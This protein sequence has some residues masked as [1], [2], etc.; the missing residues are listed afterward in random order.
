[1]FGLK[2]KAV[3]PMVQYEPES[4]LVADKESVVEEVVI[5]EMPSDNIIHTAIGGFSQPIQPM[6]DE[7]L[8]LIAEKVHLEHR[9]E[10]KTWLGIE[11]NA[12]SIVERRI[13]EIQNRT[14]DII[15]IDRARKLG[16][17]VLDL[18]VLEET[19]FDTQ[20]GLN[21]PRLILFE[22][23]TPRYD[24]YF[25]YGDYRSGMDE[26]HVDNREFYIRSLRKSFLH[27]NKLEWYRNRGEGL[28]G[29]SYHLSAYF[30]SVIP[31]EAAKLINQGCKDFGKSNVYLLA[32]YT[33]KVKVEQRNNPESSNADP[34]IMAK[35]NESVH[36][37][38]G[39]FDPTPF[40]EYI[41]R[42]H[43]S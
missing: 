15:D 39:M 1:M 40:E 10:S 34:L 3:Q 25:E 4:V 29:I 14:R 35:I 5:P 32:D 8:S 21:L 26:H 42:E 17:P 11:S 23:D 24:I 6:K 33:G 7:Y 38:L 28:R 12:K 2:R 18:K 19:Y 31:E 9:L 16:Y 36:V 27:K 22:I 37:I 41:K 43:T 20:S 30:E 13:Q